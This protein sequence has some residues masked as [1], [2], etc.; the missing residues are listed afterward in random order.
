MFPIKDK[1]NVM[2][3]GGVSDNLKEYKPF[4]LLR[5]NT[6]RTVVRQMLHNVGG[7]PWPL[8]D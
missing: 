2:G 7:G 5:T 1:G 3:V 8:I 4:R 6:K